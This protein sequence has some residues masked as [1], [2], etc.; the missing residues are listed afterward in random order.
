[1][2]ICVTATSNVNLIQDLSRWPVALTSKHARLTSGWRMTSS[3]CS[4]KNSIFY[5]KKTFCSPSRS[6]RHSLAKTMQR[7]LTFETD[8][9]AIQ[10]VDMIVCAKARYWLSCRT[11]NHKSSKLSK[12]RQRWLATSTDRL[13]A[14]T[15]AGYQKQRHCFCQ[16]RRAIL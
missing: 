14:D 16:E 4:P 6:N 7:V 8:S 5:S 2:C 11:G 3:R 15:S 12:S 1:M 10:I 13:V 9:R